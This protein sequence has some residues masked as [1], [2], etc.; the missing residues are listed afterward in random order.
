MRALWKGF[1]FCMMSVPALAATD[2]M[3]VHDCQFEVQF[4]GIKLNGIYNGPVI[5]HS[6]TLDELKVNG[7]THLVD[8]NISK[9]LYVRGSLNLDHSQAGF[10]DVFG[11]VAGEHCTVHEALNLFG[12]YIKLEHC[13]AQDINMYYGGL[14][15]FAPQLVLYK[16]KVLGKIHFYH[17]SGFVIKDAASA[18]GAV[19]NGLV[20]RS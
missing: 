10:I 11:D 9:Q 19:E 6:T 5:C 3:P 1:L 4:E 14:S 17:R 15:T 16:S 13:T 20:K 8:T 7:A 2:I 12:N 18:I